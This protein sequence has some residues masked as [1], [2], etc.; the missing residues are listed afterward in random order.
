MS[1]EQSS[2]LSARWAAV[3]GA[4][5]V[6]AVAAGCSA[7]PAAPAAS[8]SHS[9]SSTAGLTSVQGQQA[10]ARNDSIQAQHI[11]LGSGTGAAA[12]GSPDAATTSPALTAGGLST[13][14]YTSTGTDGGLYKPQGISADNGTVYVSNTGDNQV[15]KI[16]SGTTT[17]IAG[18]LEYSGDKGDGGQASASY[19]SHPTGTAED[20]RGDIFIADTSD[21]VIREI[22]PS[23]VIRRFAGNGTE[24]SKLAPGKATESELDQPQAVAV[25]SNGDVLIADTGNNRVLAVTPSGK[26]GVVAGDGIAGDKGDGGQAAVAELNQPAGL[27]VDGQD[28]VY[29]ADSSNNVIRR[30]DAKTGHITTVAGDYAADAA[31]GGLG[32]DTGDGGAAT[33]ARLNDPQGIA[34]DSSGNLFI[35]DTFNNAVRAVTPAG[36]IATLWT[37]L[38]TPYAVAADPT[39]PGRVYI[40]VTDSS[41]VESGTYSS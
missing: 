37:G 13:V 22:T 24:G 25:T 19:V 5:A 38:N 1:P 12:A 33:K 18:S 14:T 3:A 15:S 35:A 41:K 26:I 4:I 31:E 32:G 2:R 36:T 21:N 28:N 27:A 20:S 6:T 17:P 10:T 11:S 34:I 9:A 16:A 29:I 39:V 23:G 8:G 7:A 30:V 40:A